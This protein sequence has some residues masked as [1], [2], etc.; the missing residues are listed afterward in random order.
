MKI[1][2]LLRQLDY[3][4]ATLYIGVPRRRKLPTGESP[5]REIDGL[6]RYV[7]ESKC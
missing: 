4:L 3:D 6:S 1:S 5:V 7:K 2:R